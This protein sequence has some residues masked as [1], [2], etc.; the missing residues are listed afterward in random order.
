MIIQVHLQEEGCHMLAAPISSAKSLRGTQKEALRIHG[1]TSNASCFHIMTVTQS[2]SAPSATNTITVSLRPPVS[3]SADSTVV[4]SGL[5]GATTPDAML[6]L[7]NSSTVFRP[8]ARWTSASGTLVLSIATGKTLSS[9]QTAAVTFDLT[10][11]SYQQ[12]TPPFVTITV[13]GHKD[14]K[15]CV[16]KTTDDDAAPLYVISPQVPQTKSL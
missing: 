16:M 1:N 7:L 9:M 14:I 15:T 2:T 3:L 11:P 8:R 6:R 10:N 5:V 13:P 4:I 12:E